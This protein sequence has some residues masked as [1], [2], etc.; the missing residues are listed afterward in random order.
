MRAV[1]T[2]IIVRYLAR[3]DAEQ[4]ALAQAILSSGP[5]F[6]GVTVVLETCWVIERVYRRSVADTVALVRAVL[7]LPSMIVEDAVSVANAL[8]WAEA[9]LD[10][11]DAIHL[12][13]SADCADF[14]TFDAT[15]AKRSKDLS[16]VPVVLLDGG[17]WSSTR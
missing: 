17:A 8:A 14:A 12:A 16:A 5:V 3:D 13:R 15:L 9:G 1:D 11:A 7:G 2:N 10:I 4:F 6:I